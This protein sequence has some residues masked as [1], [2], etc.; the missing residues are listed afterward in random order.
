[1]KRLVPMLLLALAGCASTHSGVVP[2]G[3]GTFNL[4]RQAGS[5]SMGLGT[6]KADAY[7]EAAAYCAKDKKDFE[8]VSYDETKGPYVLGR[9]PRVDLNFR[10]I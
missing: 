5:F 7:Q 8:V 6:M 9:F 3:K 2:A 1:M 4:T 10:C